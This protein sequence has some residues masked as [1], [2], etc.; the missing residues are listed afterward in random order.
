MYYASLAY[1]FLFDECDQG[2]PF[3][4]LHFECGVDNVGYRFR[5]GD[6]QTVFK[7]GLLR[8]A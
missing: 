1:H 4:R 8:V 7:P 3:R 6:D 5:I 2:L